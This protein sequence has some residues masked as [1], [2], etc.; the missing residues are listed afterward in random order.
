L[1]K[2]QES[3]DTLKQLEPKLKFLE[4]LENLPWATCI[5]RTNVSAWLHVKQGMHG[6]EIKSG[7]DGSIYFKQGELVARL[8]DMKVEAQVA[9]KEKLKLDPGFQKQLAM[10]QGE[11]QRHQRKFKI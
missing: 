3:R 7:Q 1:K 11:P 2:L 4:R 5:D 6:V 10:K 8:K 9:I